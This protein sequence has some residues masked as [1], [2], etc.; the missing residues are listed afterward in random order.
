M[1]LLCLQ[2]VPAAIAL[3]SQLHSRQHC[4]CL[5]TKVLP[6]SA[7]HQLIA[8][9]DEVFVS[10]CTA[11]SCR[12]AKLTPALSQPCL[13]QPFLVSVLADLGP[14]VDQNQASVSS[15]PRPKA[16]MRLQVPHLLPGRAARLA[17]GCGTG[18]A[19]LRALP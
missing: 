15:R 5:S 9:P 16:C 18:H 3:T 7:D 12:H 14:S 8:G 4:R 6:S 17:G 13:L 1:H 2:T 11:R 10:T 19:P